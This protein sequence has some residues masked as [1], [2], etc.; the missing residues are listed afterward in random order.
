MKLYY[1]PGACSLSPHIVASEAG[2]AVEL[3]KVDLGTKTVATEGDFWAINPKGYVP[4][5]ELDNG[6][7]LT[8]G[9]AI[10]QYLADLRP[11]KHLAPANGTLARVRVQE[12]LNYVTAEI[13][14]T[15]SPLFRPD[16]LPTVREERLAYLKKRYALLDKQLAGRDYLFGSQ[17]SIADAYLF[18]VTR[19]AHAVKLDLSEF[20]NLQ[21]FQKRVAERPGVRAA[22]QAEGLLTPSQ[23]GGQTKVA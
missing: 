18:T 16:T 7:V 8:E 19:W 11:E 13:H 12:T 9:P 21:A 5:L 10:V 22:L 1:S 14:K 23:A 17:F 6:E 15:Y 2:I 3:V 4:T 20:P